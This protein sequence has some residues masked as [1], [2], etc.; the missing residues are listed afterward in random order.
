MASPATILRNHKGTFFVGNF[1]KL[2]IAGP[3]KHYQYYSTAFSFKY[4]AQHR[5]ANVNN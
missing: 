1:S 4:P 3:R 5:V 2:T